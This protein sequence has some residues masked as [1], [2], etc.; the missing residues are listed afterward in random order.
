MNKQEAI[1]KI[2]RIIKANTTFIE[3]HRFGYGENRLNE[4]T[5][6]QD[7]VDFINLYWGEK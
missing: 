5:L 4:K 6:K 1:N 2:E 3:T 7:L